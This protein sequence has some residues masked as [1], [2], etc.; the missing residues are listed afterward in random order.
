MV[1]M[2]TGTGGTL[3]GV[4]RKLKEKIPNIEVIAVDPVGSIL[5]E[6]DSLNKNR[7]LQ[8]YKVMRERFLRTFLFF[9]IVLTL[10]LLF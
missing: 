3:T 10:V 7:R 5:A 2:G 9:L 4:A 1:V 6:P 8:P